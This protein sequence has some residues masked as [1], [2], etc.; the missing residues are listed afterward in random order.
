MLTIKKGMVVWCVVAGLC[1]SI[2]NI[3]SLKKQEVVNKSNVAEVVMLDT[4]VEELTTQTS[5]TTIATQVETTTQK[6]SSKQFR[7]TSYYPEATSN[8]TGS[9]KCSW[10]FQVNDKGWYT[11]NGKLVLAAATTYL[12]KSFGYVEGKK[13]FRYKDVV[14]ITIDGVN[15]EG[16]VLDS[17]GAC[18]SV[19][20]EDRLD[21]FVS[22]KNYVID[23]GY[24]GRNTVEVKL[25]D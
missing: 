9:G 25:I 18:M 3:D 17:C 2:Y 8:C 11:W 7:L 12:Q 1:I 10:D 14:N 5:N 19:T 16:I 21:L 23:R 22:S 15:Y 6:V 24:K 20:Y 13:Y 4:E